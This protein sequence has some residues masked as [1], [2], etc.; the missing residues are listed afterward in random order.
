[1]SPARLLRSALLASS[2]GLLCSSA[3]A[4]ASWPHDV[5]TNLEIYN[6]RNYRN[7]PRAS[8]MRGWRLRL[9]GRLRGGRGL[10]L[11]SRAGTSCSVT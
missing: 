4:L 10:P 1:M 11:W 8:P 2:I 5:Q 6:G 9:L 7:T 3:P